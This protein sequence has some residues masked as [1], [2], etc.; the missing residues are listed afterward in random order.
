MMSLN[1][2]CS[3][4]YT[5]PA[6]IVLAKEDSIRA[7]IKKSGHEIPKSLP[8]RELARIEMLDYLHDAADDLRILDLNVGCLIDRDGNLVVTLG[9]N[10]EA[11]M[12]L[13]KSHV[14]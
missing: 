12:A 1:P 13:F 10:H 5:I 11:D 3:L 4:V 9:F 14:I 6:H 2:D 7:A 8:P